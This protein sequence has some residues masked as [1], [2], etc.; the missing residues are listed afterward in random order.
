MFPFPYFV[1]SSSSSFPHFFLADAMGLGKTVMLLAL[2]LKSQEMIS[3]KQSASMKCVKEEEDD[4]DDSLY[5]DGDVVGSNNRK[6]RSATTQRSTTLVVAKLS[7]L[8]QWSEEISSK[9]NLSHCIVYGQ[10]KRPTVQE[11]KNVVRNAE[12]T[13]IICFCSLLTCLLPHL[14][15]TIK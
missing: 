4:D 7:L 10:E 5:D 15:Q 6:K 11:L 12:R 14:F 1:E 2:I 3:S 13:I 8:P 9:T